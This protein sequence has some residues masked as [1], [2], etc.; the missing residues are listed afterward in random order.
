[1]AE[2]KRAAACPQPDCGYRYRPSVSP[3]LRRLVLLTASLLGYCYAA[4]PTAADADASVCFVAGV[5]DNH[6][7]ESMA[8]LHSIK[9]HHPCSLVMLYDLGLTQMQVSTLH[10]GLLK[11]LVLFDL[12]AS[13]HTWQREFYH[14]EKSVKPLFV[15]DALNRMQTAGACRYLFY[16]DASIRLTR[17]LDALAFST[18]Q[19]R[20]VL[21]SPKWDHPQINYTH[22]SMYKWFGYDYGRERR[23]CEGVTAASMPS[24]QCM[25]QTHSG[26]FLLD[27]HNASL[28]SRLVAPWARCAS[29]KL[30]IVPDGAFSHVTPK[31]RAEGG[32][33]G[34]KLY[35]HRAD[36][37]SFSFLLDPIMG[38]AS[39]YEAFQQP[40]SVLAY[41]QIKRGSK[42]FSAADV[43]S[44]PAGLCPSL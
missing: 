33:K 1:M 2:R 44:L 9:R 30:C 38:R 7:E 34:R 28:V 29:F 10:G 6:F 4:T 19:S 16:L 8:M 31:M 12:P 43:H 32:R 39:A 11:R 40:V 20:G 18:L 23:L 42:E 35:T 17:S 3:L 5:S 37:G 41:V 21:V 13:V 14:G 27:T 26:V 22:P 25:P 15:A 36:Q 24:S